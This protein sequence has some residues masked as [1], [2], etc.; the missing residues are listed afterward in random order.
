MKNLS[1]LFLVAISL[2]SC[3]KDSN[4]PEPNYTCFYEVLRYD[5][6]VHDSVGT[7]VGN[8]WHRYFAT[9]QEVV[10][11]ENEK[12]VEAKSLYGPNATAGCVKIR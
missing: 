12:K 3:K 4:D 6:L 7:K 2:F 10:S 11:H 9:T 5:S 1:I 8:E